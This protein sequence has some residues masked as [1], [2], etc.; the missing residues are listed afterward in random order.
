ME[1][2]PRLQVPKSIL[3]ALNQLYEMEQKL[4]T[5]GDSAN[6]RRCV[7]KMKD[8]FGEEGL[9]MLDP[10]GGL[11]RFCF[12]YEDPMGQAYNET[13]TDLEAS[14]SGVGTENLVVVEVIKP[15]IRAIAG[16]GADKFSRIIQQGIVV[17]ES[18]QKR[19]DA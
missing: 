19:P 15:I 9:P 2:R 13:R 16:E 12:V 14:I 7:S 10:M 6:L 1:P 3:V 17:V 5:D 8:A 18:R 4:K 11:T